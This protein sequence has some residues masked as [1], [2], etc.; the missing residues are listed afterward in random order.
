MTQSQARN[1]YK[2]LP[3]EAF[4]RTAVTGRSVE[5]IGIIHQ[6]KFHIGQETTLAMAGSCFAQRLLRHLRTRGFQ[7]LDLEPPPPGLTPEEEMRFGFGLYSARHG[8]I[9]TARQLRQ[10]AEEAF[11]LFTPANAIWQKAD[12][13]FDALRPTIEPNGLASAAAVKDQRRFHLRKVRDVITQAQVFVFTLGLTEAWTDV[14]TGTV[15]P[16]APGVACGEYDPAR[17]RCVNFTA[18]QVRDDLAAFLA[19]AKTHNPSMKLLL[20]VTPQWPV[21]TATGK[22]VL[23]AANYSKAVLRAAAGQLQSEHRDVDYFPSYEIATNPVA[24][25]LYFQP[26]LRTVTDAGAVAAIDAFLIAY[27]AEWQI[28]VTPEPQPADTTPQ[29]DAIR[30][31]EDV[32][33][34]DE[35]LETYAP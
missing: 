26:N 2:N 14:R 10:L 34:D 7:V 8:N 21:A 25:N 12:R 11:G 27:N 3:P 24:G 17:H 5:T 22:H 20:T 1:P 13:F 9:Y 6:P 33:C 23:V 19:L 28:P 15:Y 18:Q 35:L 4:W 31:A 30:T 16:T 32:A 29:A